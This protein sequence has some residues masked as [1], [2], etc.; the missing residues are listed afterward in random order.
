MAEVGARRSKKNNLATRLLLKGKEFTSGAVCCSDNER[1]GE[2]VK[3]LI[4][5]DSEPVRRMIKRFLRDQVDE[6]IECADGS[7]AL[8][9]YTKHHPDLVLMDIEM[10]HTDGFTAT[11][12][13][14]EA[15]SAARV[16]I[17]SQWDSPSLRAAGKEAGADDYITKMN[18]LPLRA[19]LERRVR[20]E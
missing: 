11:R 4:V 6:F 10:T 19:I 18:L 5:D 8:G 2:K 16:V 17:V 14:K 3:V 12:Q 20:D 13:I 7:D 9:C 15:F 1:L